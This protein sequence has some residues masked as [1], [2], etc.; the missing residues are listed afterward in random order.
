MSLKNINVLNVNSLI[1]VLHVSSFIIA[2]LFKRNLRLKSKNHSKVIIL[3]MN[4]NYLKRNQNYLKEVK[5][6][7]NLLPISVFKNY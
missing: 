5:K 6:L 3:M 7:E 1:V 4:I 2:N